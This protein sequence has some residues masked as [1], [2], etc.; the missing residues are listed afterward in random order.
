MERHKFSSEDLRGSLRVMFINYC[1]Y[2]N[3]NY[4][5]T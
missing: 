1:N 2:Y 4:Y 3:Y 5:W